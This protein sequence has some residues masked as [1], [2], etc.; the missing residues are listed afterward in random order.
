MN[1]DYEVFQE[2]ELIQWDSGNKT[3]LYL[4]LTVQRSPLDT[5]LP[6]LLFFFLVL[7]LLFEMSS[8]GISLQSDGIVNE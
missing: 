2:L 8:S 3:L 4:Y 5:L 7:I 6:V 1:D